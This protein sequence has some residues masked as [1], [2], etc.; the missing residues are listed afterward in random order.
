MPG[1]PNP[2]FF[3]RDLLLSAAG[4]LPFFKA[5]RASAAARQYLVYWGTYTAGGTRYG[6]CD[7]KGIYVSRFDAVTGSLSA[8][9]LAAETANPSYLAIHPLQRFL[10]A[11]NEHIDPTG[12]VMGEVSSFSIDRQTGKLTELN[13]VSSRGGMPCHICT[14]QSGKVLAVANWSTGSTAAFPIRKNGTLG[15]ATGFYQHSGERSG[16]TSPGQAI[17]VHCHAVV[18][19]PDN[20]FLI[21]TDTG[22]NK[23]FVHRLDVDGGTFAPH[24]PACLGLQNPANPRHLVFHPNAKWAY[25]ANE[26]NPGCTVLNYDPGTGVFAVAAVTRTVPEGT[27][28]RISPAEAVMHPTGRF[29]YVSNRGH[30]SIA[31]L[32]IDPASGSLTLVE[33]FQPDGSG[34]R[35]FNIDPTGKWLFALMQRSNSIV[36]LQIDRAT[37]KLARAGNSPSL[38]SPVCAKF[39]GVG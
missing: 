16:G 11:V 20:R 30:D 8:P 22:L 27:T 17:Q 5:R 14:D 32:R 2:T 21:A 31:V 3:R 38:P 37:G 4:S 26:A 12:K 23:V 9:A 24:D 25:V 19:S 35:S 39:V 29:V 18:V 1:V 28:G 15:K 13:R 36:P 33:A 34:P 7:S 6:T 10:Y